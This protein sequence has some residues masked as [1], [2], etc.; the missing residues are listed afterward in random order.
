MS[1]RHPEKWPRH[2]WRGLTVRPPNPFK[3]GKAF[4]VNTYAVRAKRKYCAGVLRKLRGREGRDL[5]LNMHV[6]VAHVLRL[7]A[8]YYY[9]YL[10]LLMLGVDIAYRFLDSRLAG[11]V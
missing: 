3:W 6:D 4:I 1:V 11:I 10:A 7:F 2:V 8:F 9:F 5:R